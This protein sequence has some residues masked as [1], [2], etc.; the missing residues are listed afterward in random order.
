MRFADAIGS[1]LFE[2]GKQRLRDIGMG[3]L[4]V[5][6]LSCTQSESFMPLGPSG[7]LPPH[8]SRLALASEHDQGDSRSI[9]MFCFQI[10][11]CGSGS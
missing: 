10:R 4:C 9:A 3:C 7:L 11:K 8:D 2:V 1:H 5:D 6:L